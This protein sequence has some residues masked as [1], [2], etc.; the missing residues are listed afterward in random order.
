M[1]RV[2]W[3]TASPRVAA[4]GA[5]QV[6]RLAGGGDVAPYLRDG[7]HY[8][9]GIM[10]SPRFRAE[11]GFDE[12]G[13]TG[14]TVPQ[15]GALVFR[16]G[17]ADLVDQLA[18]LFWI[19]APIAVEVGP[20]GGPFAAVLNGTIASAAMVDGALVLELADLSKAL[21]KPVVT[22]RFAGTGG[23][24][25][26]AEA[27]GRVKRRSWGRVFN[28]EGRVF[29]K[30]YNLY[31][32]GDPNFPIQ[33]TDVV[34]DK[35]RAAAPACALLGWQGSI[36]ATIA[37]LRA[38]VPAQGSGVVAPSIGGLVKWW[39]QPAGPLTADLRGEIGAGYVETAPE[40]AA[41]ISAAAGGPGF[42]N[43][44]TMAALRAGVAGLHVGDDAETTAQ[45]LDRLLLGVSLLWILEPTGTIRLREWS[46]AAPAGSLVARSAQRRRSFAPVRTRRVGYQRSHRLHND[47]EIVSVQLV[48][49]ISGLAPIATDPGAKDKLDGVAAGATRNPGTVSPDEPTGA[50]DG[51]LWVDTSGVFA[52]FKLRAGGAWTT[53]ANA[54]TAYNAL[55]GRPIA[56]A[57]INTTESAKLTGIE[58]N[59]DVTP[60]MQRPVTIEIEADHTGAVITAL[61]LTRRLKAMKGN[62]DVSA[63]TNWLATF[64]PSVT[65]SIDN[66][67]GGGD[68]GVLTITGVT[69]SGDVV[70]EAQTAPKV[71]ERIPVRFNRAPA[72]TSGGGGGGGGQ[73]VSDNSWVT[74]TS[75]SHAAVSD[76]LSIAANAAGELKFS[77]S[78]DFT[79]VSGV[80]GVNVAFKAQYEAAGVWTDVGAEI[81]GTASTYDA[82]LGIHNPGSVVMYEVTR[83]GLTAGATYPVRLVA[84]G[85]T[86]S[87]GVQ[88]SNAAF[89]VRQ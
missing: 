78:A 10:R 82:E 77:A 47:G 60:S 41:R 62:S 3:V 5:V 69:G 38:S 79:P 15:T 18:A 63:A 58:A 37:A 44:G 65:G 61:P 87:A 26:G 4:T 89:L 1:S 80:F 29:D 51:H 59:A 11:L 46:F 67:A 68:R 43:A 31:E 27:A 19:D 88:W 52:V 40:I 75:S 85:D 35:G 73:S 56:L 33:Q 14:G 6:V 83:S 21:D 86:G 74:I 64:P 22:A 34:R 20:E 17:Q 57:D 25:G 84:R 39:T 72:P 50:V 66:T 42:A 16:P 49:D 53:G 70:V 28:V 30:A 7:V 55:T 23:A 71:V 13:W 81:G 48:G 9:A 76:T 54:L 8:R 24:E 45:A 12:N 2:V 36:D 32:F